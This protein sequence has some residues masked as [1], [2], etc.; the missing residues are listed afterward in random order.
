MFLEMW[1][2]NFLSPFDNLSL[3]LERWS[4]IQFG[5]LRYYSITETQG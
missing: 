4:G 3:T 2:K 1:Y 5:E